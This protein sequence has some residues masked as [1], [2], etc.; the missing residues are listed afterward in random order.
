M[1]IIYSGTKHIKFNIHAILEQLCLKKH[2]LSANVGVFV[3]YAH[4]SPIWGRQTKDQ[5]SFI[6]VH[7]I[8]I[9]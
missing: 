3:N 2:F 6:R 8:C 7:R 4:I 9:I 1:L 5:C